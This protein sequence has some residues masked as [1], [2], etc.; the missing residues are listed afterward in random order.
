[1]K[2]SLDQISQQL[3]QAQATMASAATSTAANAQVEERIAKVEQ[4]LAQIEHAPPASS[5]TAMADQ[6]EPAA[7][8]Q[9]AAPATPKPAIHKALHH[10][11]KKHVSKKASAKT[12]KHAAPSAPAEAP[13]QTAAASG[14]WVLRAATP[15]EAWVAKDATTPELK[16]VR[17]GDDLPG[18]GKVQAI[19]QT[20]DSWAI[21]GAQGT[22]R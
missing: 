3:V 16:H 14:N 19:H 21:E 11:T 18:I 6:Q 4:H 20:G 12:A 13:A 1:M 9:A 22:V 10:K 17:V 7:A 8:T 15:D 2:K 5:L